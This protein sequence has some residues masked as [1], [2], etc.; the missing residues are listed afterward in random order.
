MVLLM[1]MITADLENLTDLQP[2]SGCND[3]DFPYM[4][5][6]K[7]GN[8]GEVSQKETCVSLKETITIPRS[9]G[10]AHLFQKPYPRKFPWTWFFDY[11][12]KCKFCGRDGTVAMIEGRGQPLT[13]SQSQSGKYAPLMLFDCRGYEPV[14]FVFADGWKAESLEGTRFEN[15]DLSSGDFAD[16]DEK[17]ECPVTISNLRS[18]F[19]VVK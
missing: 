6:V 14:D 1:L 18:T 3:P 17:G 9:R 16:Y 10:I 15:I 8:C 13:H 5:K 12:P 11:A 4:F 7:C 19:E 2:Q